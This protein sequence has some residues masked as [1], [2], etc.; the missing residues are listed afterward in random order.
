MKSKLDIY[1]LSLIIN[2]YASLVP[3]KTHFFTDLASELHEKLALGVKTDTMKLEELLKKPNL[4]SDLIPDITSYNN[5]WLAITC[6][7]IKANIMDQSAKDIGDDI[8]LHGEDQGQRARG[9]VRLIAKDL[10]KVFNGNK[11][12]KNTDLTVSEASN[13]AIAI[14][15]LRLEQE[16]FIADVGDIIRANLKNATN[17]D[18]VNLAKSTYYFR[19]FHHTRD[20][21][22]Q[23]HAECVSRFNLRQ[24]DD[25]EKEALAK[26]FSHHGIM[27]DSP[28]AN[29]RVSR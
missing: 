26:I 8:D 11:R 17:T 14:A 21:Y 24:F 3:E 28:F 15:S 5:L 22:S 27:T 16:H 18:L 4:I 10:I 19:N 20:L 13:I 29:V 9:F 1:Y 12:W 7:G 23:I 2:S 6:F 25:E